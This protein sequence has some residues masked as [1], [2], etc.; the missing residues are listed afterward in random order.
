MK[1]SLDRIG[2][3]IVLLLAS[4]SVGNHYLEWRLFGE[5]SKVIMVGMFV[6][7]FIYL[8]FIG[9]ILEGVQARR[10]PKD[11]EEHAATLRPWLYL[12]TLS[13]VVLVFAL[14][15]PGLQ[16]ARGAPI[17][18]EDWIRLVVIEALVVVAGI[19]GWYRLKRSRQKR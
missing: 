6:V 1:L 10:K 14:A 5:L 19:I 9:P 15:G 11:R 13:T 17:Q 16:L 18:R 3:G 8:A 7:L 12:L 2:A 4:L